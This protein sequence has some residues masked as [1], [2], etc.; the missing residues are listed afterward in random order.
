MYDLLETDK[1]M[2]FSICWLFF[3]TFYQP[4]VSLLANNF[5]NFL[6]NFYFF[7]EM[8]IKEN[9]WIVWLNL[10]KNFYIYFTPDPCQICWTSIGIFIS[11]VWRANFWWIVLLISSY[12]CDPLLTLLDLLPWRMT[13]ASKISFPMS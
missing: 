2:I 11:I 9:I 7:E 4:L 12:I 5:A 3:A 13:G 6:W 1:V 8:Q 10:A